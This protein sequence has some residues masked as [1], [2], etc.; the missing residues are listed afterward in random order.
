MRVYDWFAPAGTDPNALVAA[1]ELALP[2]LRLHVPQIAVLPYEVNGYVNTS[3][4][5]DGSVYVCVHLFDD[6]YNDNADVPIRP[7]PVLTTAEEIQM[8]NAAGREDLR[9]G[10]K[11]DGKDKAADLAVFVSAGF[12]VNDAP[13]KD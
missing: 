13:M 2:A 10:R 8:L 1:I 7:A 5:R 3:K 9:P 4:R 11:I 6:S 12:G